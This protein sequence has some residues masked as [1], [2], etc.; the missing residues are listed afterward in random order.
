MRLFLHRITL[1]H[2]YTYLRIV[3]RF[4]TDT[5][6]KFINRQVA[7]LVDNNSYAWMMQ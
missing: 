4:C 1:S 5:L 6:T 3:K 2:T 7:V